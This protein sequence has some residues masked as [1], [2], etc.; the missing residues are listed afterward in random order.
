[1][2]CGRQN[3]PWLAGHAQAGMT[4]VEVVV[5]L[6][7]SSVAIAGIISGYLYCV[8][9]AEKSALSLA[10]NARAVQCLEQTRSAKWDLSIWPPVDE[11]DETNFPDTVVQLDLAG[12]GTGAT[13]ATNSIRIQL[14]ATNP[15]LKQVHVDCVWCFKGQQLI[16]N[17]IETCRA[18][19]Q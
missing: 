17:S 9:E 13:S 19:D 1:M 11:L 6:A 3:V 5:A 4:L 18:P 7:I 15:P 8:E 10:A 12:I 2:I 16:T 14:V